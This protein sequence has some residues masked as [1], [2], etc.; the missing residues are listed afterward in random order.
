MT[1]AMT[2]GFT[3]PANA[4]EDEIRAADGVR[5]RT[6]RWAPSSPARG[7]VA[8]L[9]G[10]GEFIEK[11]FEVV[12]ELLSRR[13]AVA[14]MDWRGQGGSDRPLRNA[15]K[16]HV[17]DFAYFG[18]DLEAFVAAVLEPHCPRPW[19]GL[20]H[21]MGAAVLLAAAEA[22]RCPF[23]R[24]VLTSPMIALNGVD[25]RGAAQYLVE[26]L[27]IVGLGGAFLPGGGG[28][29]SLWSGP[30]QGNVLTSDAARFAR[31][32]KVVEV[33][34]SVCVGAPTIG[35]VH[36]AFRFMRRFDEPNFPRRIAAPIL[37]IAAGADQV[38]DSVAA[39]RFA[40]RLP[41]GR[42]I[43]IDGA[44]HEIMIERDVVRAQFWSAFDQFVPGSEFERM[45]VGMTLEPTW[46]ESGVERRRSDKRT[47]RLALAILSGF[48]VA[49]LAFAFSL[50]RGVDE[51]YTLA[52]SRHLS[53]S[54]FDHPPLHLWIA[55]FAAL[56]FGESAAARLPFVALFAATGWVFYRL[57]F[58]LFGPVA[59]LV[60]LLALNVTP[61]FFASAGSWIVP[62]GPLLLALAA[63]A[64]ALS[65]L[66][67]T[68][69]S[70]RAAVWR[71]WLV[72]GACMG[73]AGLSKYNA[74]VSAAGL[75][76]FVAFAREQRRWFK[77]PAPYAAVVLAV[78]M[79]TPVIVWNARHGWVSFEFQGT[80]G[81]PGRGLQP[82][83]VAAMALG[84]VAY[85]SPWM[86]APLVAA[87]V[88]AWRRRQDERR[89]FLL[90]L[91]L[92]PIVLFTLT[93]LWGARG[94]PHWTMPGWFFASALLGA[95]VNEARPAPRA[96]RRWALVSSG[97]LAGIAALAVLQAATGWPLRLTNDRPGLA[98]PT[99]EAFEW[100]ALRDAPIFRPGPAFV[101][102]A[103]WSDAGKIAIALGPETPVIVLS[104]DPR[105][106]AFLYDSG[107]FIGRNG[108]LIVRAVELQDA[109]GAARPY[110]ASIGQPQ[111]L[112]LGRNGRAEIELA[113][114]PVEGLT[115]P[116]PTP[117]RSAAG[118]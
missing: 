17:D 60:A 114:V 41:N 11:Y 22:G 104:T 21:S 35:W 93:P 77:H 23:E 108:V 56:A 1:L 117:Y 9:G 111:R 116:L 2:P 113:L 25:H 103:K 118:R 105:G 58:D 13:F 42:I 15:C 64:W 16:G 107:N 8:I 95:W 102:S 74:V 48:L 67:F 28:R 39:E 66:F 110:F 47:D 29:A 76:G 14:L 3:P 87:L 75:A 100:R 61:F 54:Y 59:A 33:S 72:A 30:F 63:A 62:D 80:R 26:A 46:C 99:L 50:G 94:L 73:L 70:D 31:T 43:V 71:L 115:R 6:A 86:F 5:L 91:S 68:A 27:D 10:R 19:F 112:T 7:T 38:T 52:I 51:S 4:I 83:Q 69:P 109:L 88:S 106:W 96:L 97:L 65:R 40:S 45:P 53:L 20:G 55:H 37:I 57:T 98:D 79:I 101:I 85:L 89:L 84:E 18:R 92:P 24:L 12:R 44:Q 32:A 82:A 78:A 34:P 81:A 36:A 90:C 49:R